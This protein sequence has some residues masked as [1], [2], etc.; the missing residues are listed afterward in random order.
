MLCHWLHIRLLEIFRAASQP[1]WWWKHFWYNSSTHYKS[2][3]TLSKC[4]HSVLQ[5]LL[6]QLYFIPVS[7]CPVQTWATSTGTPAWP[8][9]DPWE[10]LSSNVSKWLAPLFFS[11]PHIKVY[12][13]SKQGHSYSLVC[14]WSCTAL[15]FSGRRLR[16]RPPSGC[17]QRVAHLYVACLLW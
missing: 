14:R 7:A 4:F 17:S 12:I 16:A 11:W 13:S 6:H 1:G 5:C 8:L 2:L 9:H 15:C 10:D 3:L